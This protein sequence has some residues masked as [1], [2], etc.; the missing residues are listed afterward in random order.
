MW[1]TTDG[2]TTYAMEKCV[3]KGGIPPNNKCLWWRRCKALLASRARLSGSTTPTTLPAEQSW[4][5]GTRH[6]RPVYKAAS[7]TWPAA[8]RCSGVTRQAAVLQ[9]LISTTSTEG[10]PLLASTSIT[11]STA[12]WALVIRVTLL[13]HQDRSKYFFKIIKTDSL[14]L[15]VVKEQQHSRFINSVSYTH[16][17]LPTILRV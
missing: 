17:T 13:L 11:F 9:C 15:H 4:C 3:A 10:S 7:W 6:S 14:Q 8:S 12:A 5:P 16:L 1:Q 2:Q